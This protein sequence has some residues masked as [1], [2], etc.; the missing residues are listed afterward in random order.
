MHPKPRSK[1]AQSPKALASE[2]PIKAK[3]ACG[4]YL[5]STPIGNLGDFSA[6]GAQTLNAADLVLAEDTRNTKKLMSAYG[7]HAPIERA[8]EE[9]TENAIRKALI[10]LEKGGAVAFA[11]DAGT[12]SICD[13]GQRLA[14]A[15]IESGFEVFPIPGASSLLAAL[16]S[17]GLDARQFVFLGFVP[18]KAGARQAFIEN[19]LGLAMTTVMFETGPR[20]LSSL[21][22]LAQFSPNRQIAVARELTKFFEEK[23]RGSA[24][25]ILHHYQN[26]GAPKGEI[27]IVVEGTPPATAAF[28]SAALEAKIIEGLTTEGI[29]DLSARLARETGQKKRDIYQLALALS[30]GAP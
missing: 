26:N 11:S 16:V 27:V 28:D 23:K 12:P 8:D 25:E 21:E 24:A 30:K 4:L 2:N 29:K 9:A 19:A 3:L 20:L 7:V 17:S 15:I 6:R 5:V 13:P 14:K 22:V 18:N 1:N 10:V